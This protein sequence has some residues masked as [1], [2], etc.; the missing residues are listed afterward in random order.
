MKVCNLGSLNMDF[1]Y[2]VD[3]FVLPGETKSAKNVSRFAGGK[4]LNQSVAL[5]KAKG[6]VYHGAPLGR[7][8]DFLKKTLEDYGVKTD[9][10][11]PVEKNSGHA[12]IQVE[13]SG[14]NCILLY[15][16]SNQAWTEEFVDRLGGF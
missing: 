16:G 14:Q 8:G 10:L 11:I 2:R 4:G 9:Y 3:H 13:D 7:D 6:E 12:I 5:A 1:V 15:G